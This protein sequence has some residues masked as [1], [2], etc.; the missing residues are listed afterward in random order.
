MM[1]T[2]LQKLKLK[3]A[4]RIFNSKIKQKLSIYSIFKAKSKDKILLIRIQ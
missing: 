1:N 4:D 3:T 2:Q